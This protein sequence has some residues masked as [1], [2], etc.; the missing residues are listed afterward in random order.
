MTCMQ[1]TYTGGFS[2]VQTIG[3]VFLALVGLLG[4]L[5]MCYIVVKVFA[6]GWYRGRQLY[7][8]SQI[9]RSKR[10]RQHTK[11]GKSESE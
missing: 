8:E 10:W 1:L 11:S 7:F 5:L 4:F 3:I 9:R 6:F 2:F